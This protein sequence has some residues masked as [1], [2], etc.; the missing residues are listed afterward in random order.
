MPP[1]EPSIPPGYLYNVLASGSRPFPYRR[2]IRSL[3]GIFANAQAPELTAAGLPPVALLYAPMHDPAAPEAPVVQPAE[4]QLQAYT[5]A[6]EA[7]TAPESPDQPQPAHWQPH[8]STLREAQGMEGEGAT[9]S[10]QPGEPSGQPAQQ[11]L[12]EQ[13]TGSGRETEAVPELS[14]SRIAVVALTTLTIPGPSSHHNTPSPESASKPPG[15]SLSYPIPWQAAAQ[16]PQEP[17]CIP[18]AMALPRTAEVVQPCALETFVSSIP[19]LSAVLPQDQ[20]AFSEEQGLVLLPAVELKGDLPK[21]APTG[22]TEHRLLPAEERG[23]EWAPPTTTGG[24]LPQ[25]TGRQSRSAHTGTRA[26]ESPALQQNPRVESPGTAPAPAAPPVT[27]PALPHTTEVA[28]PREAQSIAFPRQVPDV[29]VVQSEP[30]VSAVEQRLAASPPIAPGV[31]PGKAGML[32]ACLQDGSAVPT[33]SLES[34]VNS[35]SSLAPRGI[36]HADQEPYSAI[37]QAYPPQNKPLAVPATPPAMLHTAEHLAR[38]QRQVAELTARV[39]AQQEIKTPPAPMPPAPVPPVPPA[40][41]PGTSPAFWE[42][43]YLHR[44]YRW[45]RR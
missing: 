20:T 37:L 7:V 23:E 41:L 5:V 6:M 32:P 28:V 31:A 45:A 43:H 16:E 19:S 18:Q 3:L 12:P 11:R 29:L 40:P 33:A 13:S 17:P 15:T 30:Q 24:P 10:L 27:T 9:K 25:G 8:E 36:P 39:E 21:K 4:L 42:R 14:E 26:G 34:E 2:G 44:L 35:R 22:R 38:L 1:H